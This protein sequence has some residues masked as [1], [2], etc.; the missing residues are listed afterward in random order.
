MFIFEFS[1][2]LLTTVAFL[3]N[4]LAVLFTKINKAMQ[5]DTLYCQKYSHVCLH[6]DMSFLMHRV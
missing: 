6:M 1:I 5:S 4:I 2:V 3:P